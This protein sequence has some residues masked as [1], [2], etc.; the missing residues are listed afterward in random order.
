MAYYEIA[1]LKKPTSLKRHDSALFSDHAV[2][3]INERNLDKLVSIGT[4]RRFE[5]AYTC[6]MSRGGPTVRV[7]VLK[8]SSARRRGSYILFVLSGKR[9]SAVR[10][11]SGRFRPKMIYCRTIPV[12]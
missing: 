8:D 9:T 7:N 4:V 11:C 6:N 3:I 1:D 10:A 5:R 2:R 12:V